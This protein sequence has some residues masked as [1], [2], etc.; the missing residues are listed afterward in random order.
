MWM[1]RLSVPPLLLKVKSDWAL[2]LPA[3]TVNSSPGCTRFGE[4]VYPLA[5]ATRTGWVGSIWP[6]Q[7]NLPDCGL[8]PAAQPPP[9]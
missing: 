5:V 8:L 4:I 1:D 9:E 7:M 6:E 2:K 3:L